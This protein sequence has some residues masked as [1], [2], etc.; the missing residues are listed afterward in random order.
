MKNFQQIRSMERNKTIET[1]GH[2]TKVEILHTLKSNIIENTF[3]LENFEPFP[4]YHGKN[5]PS[6]Y[7][8]HNLFFAT[9]REYSYDE[10]SRASVKIRNICNLSFGARPA[11]LFIFNKKIPAIR[12]KEL[13]SFEQIPELQKWYMNEDIFFAKKKNFNNEGV[14]KVWKHFELD[15]IENGIYKDLEVPIIYYLQIPVPLSW[16]VFESMTYSIKNNLDNSNFDAA[17]G[18][19]YLKEIMDV[20]R[21]YE[22]GM[23]VDFL[24]KLRDNYLEEIRKLNL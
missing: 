11:E 13:G 14:I 15:E 22:K 5:L 2:I 4:G 17:L 23:N 20:V 10:I 1:F 16:K 21:I 19:I 8:P 7:D 6:G 12:V 3:V 9:K 18:V 24:K